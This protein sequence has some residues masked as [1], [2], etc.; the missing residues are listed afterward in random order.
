M[1]KVIAMVSIAALAGAGI[2]AYVMARKARNTIAD[3][4]IG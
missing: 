3:I 2:T 1:V 4:I